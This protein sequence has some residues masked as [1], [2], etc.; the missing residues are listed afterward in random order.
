MEEMK[1]C[2]LDTRQTFGK[3]NKKFLYRCFPDDNSSP[4]L[5]PYE[6]PPQFQKKRCAYYVLVSYNLP[7]GK[8]IHNLGEVSEPSH[9]YE[10][11]LYCKNLH[12]SQRE[13]NQIVLKKFKDVTWNLPIREAKVFTIDGPSSIDLDDGFSVDSEKVSVYISCVPYVLN[14]LDLW[15]HMSSRVSTIY[16]P[17]KRHPMLPGFLSTLCSLN[18]GTERPCLIL[19]LYLDG[20]T[21]W[22]LCAV[23]IHKN[24]TYG[25]VTGSD[26]NTLLE[27]SGCNTSEE[28][29]H[30]YMT[31][32]NQESSILKKG[33]HLKIHKPDM[34][35]EDWLPVYFN[36]YSF[37]DTTG[38]YAQM[39]SP[40]RRL[41]DI[42][43][44]SQ[45][46]REL[47]LCPIQDNGFHEE[48]YQKLDTLNTQYRS[49]R[50]AQN[51]A[52]LL[53]LFDKNQH[54]VF[55]GIVWDQ[56][57]YLKELGLMIPF[58]SDLEER[59]THSFKIYVFHDESRLRRK[60]RLQIS[61]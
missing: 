44:M 16:F 54:K 30:H 41:V 40:I 8:L 25:N 58:P 2:I 45:L 15:K 11:L 49:I 43:N 33:I 37:Y 55:E 32:Y 29:V 22:S 6:I 9:Y 13:F 18:E 19:D 21:K 38:D 5:V 42:L 28:L 34:L 46:M 59:S 52:K 48:W 31:R 20:S 1:P 23:K 60:I 47:D 56:K 51:T 36:Q 3:V 10:Y 17:D 35:P 12:V 26:F 61:T 57:L 50:K 39:T 14:Q 27:R 7:V 4:L 24:F 53:D